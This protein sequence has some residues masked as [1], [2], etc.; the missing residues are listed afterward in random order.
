MA[1]KHSWKEGVRLPVAVSVV[2][3]N[4]ANIGDV[5]EIKHDRLNFLTFENSL[6]SRKKN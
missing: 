1:H 2:R 6:I 3:N 4:I 5:K